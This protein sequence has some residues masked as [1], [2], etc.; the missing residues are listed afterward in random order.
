MLTVGGG[1]CDLMP[2]CRQRYFSGY[3][4]ITWSS[5]AK[6]RTCACAATQAPAV[7]FSTPC[8][9]EGTPDVYIRW[10]MGQEWNQEYQSGSSYS[11]DRFGELNWGFW[12]KRF[13]VVFGGESIKSY[14]FCTSSW[15]EK[16]IPFPPSKLSQRQSVSITTYIH[17]KI[18]YRYT[19][20]GGMKKG[21]RKKEC[22]CK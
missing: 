4:H 8:A 7:G 20:L 9:M 3:K 6:N 17:P 10:R 12:K 11:T 18:L 13:C 1:W 19:Y 21:R 16:D 15:R 14:H 22:I 2:I 5:R